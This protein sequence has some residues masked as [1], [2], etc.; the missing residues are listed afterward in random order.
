MTDDKMELTLDDKI[1]LERLLWLAQVA[2]AK[3]FNVQPESWEGHGELEVRGVDAQKITDALDRWRT[4]INGPPHAPA[5]CA[6]VKGCIDV[7][8]DWYK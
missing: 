3:G 2:L 6:G 4:R 7:R 1:K 5:S 8:D